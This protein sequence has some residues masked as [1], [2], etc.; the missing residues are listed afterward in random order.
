[1]PVDT[2]RKPENEP[3]AVKAPE[4]VQESPLKCEVFGRSLPRNESDPNLDTFFVDE[5]EGIVGVFDGMSS[6]PL[7]ILASQAAQEFLG[8]PV[9]FELF[10]GPKTIR[11]MEQTMKKIFELIWLEIRKKVILNNVQSGIGTTAV[12]GKYW[13]DKKGRHILT[14]GH[15][16]DSRLYRRRGD[17]IT[18]MTADHSMANHALLRLPD[19]ESRLFEWQ[20]QIDQITTSAQFREFLRARGLRRK[21]LENVLQYRGAMTRFLSGAVNDCDFP[22]VSHMQAEHEDE[23]YLTTDGAH[24]NVPLPQ[25]CEIAC[26]DA[27]LSSKVE[28]LLVAASV[29]AE[30]GSEVN[31]HFGPDDRTVA[32]LRPIFE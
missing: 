6:N 1:M 8:S 12:V 24:G 19:G 27:S 10:K 26:S 22:V 31:F 32:A 25:F 14:A 15:L 9:A 3:E 7:S 18:C 16:G 28:H 4:A 23:F 17:S 30:Q 13:R 11:Q 21:R 29:N 5:A 2:P 20:R